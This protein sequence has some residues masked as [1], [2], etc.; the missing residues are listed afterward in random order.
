M[1]LR[2][3]NYKRHRFPPEII[4]H[5]VWLYFCFPLSLRLAEE[6]PFERGILAALGMTCA[7]RMS[8]RMS[9]A[10]RILAYCGLP[11]DDRCLAFHKK[12]RPVRTASAT[13]LVMVYT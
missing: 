7:T 9:K 13:Q 12:D 2:P 8:W 5:A 4:A 1:V 11:W 6:M 10:R 3:V